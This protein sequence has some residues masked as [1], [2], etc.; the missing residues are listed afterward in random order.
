MY[1]A[2]SK[3]DYEL[4]ERKENH[5]GRALPSN[6]P[7]S[8][9]Y[10]GNF[11]ELAGQ[12]DG[13][14]VQRE[15]HEQATGYKPNIS[16]HDERGSTVQEAHTSTTSNQDI[17][18][19]ARPK[20]RL[21]WP[22]S[23]W[24]FSISG[25]TALCIAVLVINASLTIAVSKH[26]GGFQHGLGT[27]YRGDC[28][29][30]QYYNTGLHVVINILSTSLLAGSNFCMQCLSAPTREEVDE[31][32]SRRI[33]LDIGVPSFKNL[34]YIRKRKLVLWLLLGL[35]SVPLHLL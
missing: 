8:K 30:T 4:I 25:W 31:A 19:L 27:L 14:K 13:S 7:L 1:G 2:R 24:R 18:P 12:S 28:K 3:H 34:A 35:S 33:A 32:H 9:Y 21:R 29:T 26:Q 5:V 20:S 17:D 23:G 22:T 10:K 15:P 11:Y 16:E 6:V